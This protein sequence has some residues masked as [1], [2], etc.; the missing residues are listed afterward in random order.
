M[1]DEA[2]LTDLDVG[3]RPEPVELQ[4]KEPVGVVEGI[5]AA[6]QRERG[7]S[8]EAARHGWSIRTA[9]AGGSR[10]PLRAYSWSLERGAVRLNQSRLEKGNLLRVIQPARVH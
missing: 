4:F 8:G 2:A 10:E 6:I 1:T 9:E 5:A 3:E 7:E